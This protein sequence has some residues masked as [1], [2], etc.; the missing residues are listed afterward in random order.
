[1]YLVRVKEPGKSKQPWDY[2]EIVKTI[3]PEEAFPS[4]EAQ[5]CPLVAKK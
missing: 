3:P 4:V 1:M 5:A 2:Y